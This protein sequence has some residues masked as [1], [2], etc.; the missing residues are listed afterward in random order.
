MNYDLI[1]IGGGPGGYLACERAAEAGLSVL[2]VERDNLGGVCLNEGCIPTKTLLYSAKLYDG[3]KNG[4]KYGISVENIEIDHKKVVA[5]KNK[6]VKLLVGGVKSALKAK[7]VTVVNGIG[8]IKGFSGENFE[9]EVEGESYIAKNLIIATGSTSV[10]PPIE[11]VKE[12]I[13]SGK[14]LTNKE[15]LSLSEVPNKLVVVGGGVI[16]LEMASYYNSVGSEVVV[17]EMLDHIAGENDAEMGE[18]LKKNYEKHG[19]KFMLSTKVVKFSE[20]SVSCVLENGE[21]MELEYDCALMSVGRR[22]N[23]DIGLENIGVGLERGAIITDLQMRTN[24]NNCYAVGDCNGISMLAH[25]AYREAEV[26]KNT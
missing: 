19:I 22:A 9:I 20:N 11:G 3:A 18:I 4:D 15:V 2:C 14:I 25:T 21:T 13:E 16:G 8:K 12:G 5:R 23:T 7:G 10:I 17:V 26:A 24:I 6:V 1:V